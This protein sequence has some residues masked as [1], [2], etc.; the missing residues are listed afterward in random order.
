MITNDV[1]LFDVLRASSTATPRMTLIQVHYAGAQPIKPVEVI[2]IDGKSVPRP[3]PSL[4]PP[5]PPA[6]PAQ[7]S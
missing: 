4:P 6:E 1:N 7:E 5:P 2:A 3:L